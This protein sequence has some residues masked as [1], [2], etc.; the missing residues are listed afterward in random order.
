MGKIGFCDLFVSLHCL[1]TKKDCHSGAYNPEVALALER[2][3]YYIDDIIRV[4]VN[5]QIIYFCSQLAYPHQLL[6]QRAP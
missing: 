5:L 3:V 1:K 4:S 6:G 2:N